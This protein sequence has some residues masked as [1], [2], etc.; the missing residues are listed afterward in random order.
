MK[1]LLLPLLVS[2]AIPTTVNANSMVNDSLNA[3]DMNFNVGNIQM[4]CNMV[5]MAILVANSPEIYGTTSSSLKSEVKEY[6]DRCDL[7]F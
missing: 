1:R 6:A 3:A 7:R 5:S 2:L 4:A